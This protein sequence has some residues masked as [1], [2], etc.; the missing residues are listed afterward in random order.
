MCLV[1]DESIVKEMKIGSERNITPYRPSKG[2]YE[3]KPLYSDH[4]VIALKLDVQRSGINYHQNKTT[5]TIITGKGYKK[6][7][8]LL[9]EKS[10][11]SVLR[12]ENVLQEK[13][14]TWTRTIE[15]L[16][17]KVMTKVER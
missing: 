10:V 9:K 8:E 15:G 1:N 12:G 3:K 14:A 17:T 11:S 5:K 6:Y 13:Y 2:N 7:E 16:I 4:H